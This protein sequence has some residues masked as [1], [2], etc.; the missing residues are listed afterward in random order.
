MLLRAVRSADAE[1]WARE[2]GF[3]Q[4]AHARCGFRETERLVKFCKTLR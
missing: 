3:T 2:H 1:N 4:L